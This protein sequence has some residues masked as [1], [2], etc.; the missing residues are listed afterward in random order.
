MEKEV[1]DRMLAEFGELNDKV[2]KCRSFLLDEEKVKDLDNLQRDL[3]VAQL[4]AMESYLS[5]LSIR[6]GLTAP[7]TVSTTEEA[8][9]GE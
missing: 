8:A 9:T 2:T 7:E 5:V 6:I 1:L 3:L 4:K